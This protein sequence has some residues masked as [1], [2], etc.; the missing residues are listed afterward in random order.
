VVVG[1]AGDEGE[2]VVLQRLGEY[3]GVVDHVLR[4]L[5]ERGIERLLEPH[6]LAGDVVHE[7]PALP[8]GEHR[9]VDVVRELLVAHHDPAAT[10][11]DRLV[12]ASSR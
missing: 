1:A 11:P 8:A 3:L 2:P 9:L 6:R 10:G 12:R 4:V 7:R 5:V